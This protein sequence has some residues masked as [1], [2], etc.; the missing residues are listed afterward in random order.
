M[1]GADPTGSRLDWGLAAGLAAAAL[2]LLGVLCWPVLHAPSAT[3]VGPG[4]GDFASIA[5]SLWRTAEHFPSLPPSQHPDVLYPQGASLLMAAPLE[6]W[7][8]APLTRLAGPVVVFNLLQLGHLVLAAVG[9]ALL[10][11]ELGA[12]RW[13]A[14]LAASTF[15]ASPVLLS[16]IH[17]GNADV[18]P[19]FAVPLAGLL[20][21]R[22]TGS[23]GAAVLAG[24]GIGLAPWLNPYVGMMAAL[25][26]VV[27]VA[28]PSTAVELG[29]LGLSAALALGLALVY[30]GAVQASLDGGDNM[31]FKGG[32]MVPGAGTATL[33]GFLLPDGGDAPDAWTRH[34][35]YLGWSPLLLV[36]A[37]SWRGVAGVGRC[38]GLALLGL[39]LAVEPV[40]GA[41]LDQLPVTR[42][43][44]LV[45][46]YAAL[47]SLG[48]GLAAALAPLPRVLARLAPAL[49]LAEL[50]L[51]GGGRGLLGSSP[52]P[53]Q[54]ACEALAGLEPG[55]VVNLPAS[56]QDEWLLDQTCHGRPVAQGIKRPMTRPV[57]ETLA[58]PGPRAF[59]ELRALGF[60]YLV[61][62]PEGAWRG[63]AL[64]EAAREDLG[65]Y[66]ALA[67][68]LDLVAA[69]VDGVVVVDLDRD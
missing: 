33:V 50:L 1:S 29:R 25:A 44:Q 10:A 42:Q 53:A 43:L 36:L 67:R 22:C 23:W 13:G 2:L 19:V 4:T 63:Q 68:A 3:V 55:P 51:I 47:V 9:A 7:L 46:R 58:R 11:R 45:Y 6:G 5:W 64:D 60:R 26:A 8:L 14:A 17:N 48:V 16:S 52:A 40:G 24:L 31:V 66:L 62:T 57:R 15:A 18:S 41:W 28:R 37:A 34:A 65:E 49:V 21:R 59:R 54:P 61:L 56:H 27:L 12:R 30:F 38:L 32:A 20:A 35:W 39:L 69:E